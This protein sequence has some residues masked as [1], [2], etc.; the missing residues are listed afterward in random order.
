MILSDGCIASPWFWVY[1][2]DIGPAAFKLITIMTISVKLVVWRSP[3]IYIM[4]DANHSEICL[5]VVLT[6]VATQ[7]R[8][9]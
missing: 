5:F 8:N 7:R 2:S 3:N 9:K 1:L 6:V 4:V